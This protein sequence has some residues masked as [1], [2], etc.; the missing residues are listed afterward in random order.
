MNSQDMISLARSEGFSAAA[1]A[2]MRA[3]V[4]DSGFRKY[5]EE[6]LCGRY[7]ANYSCPPDCGTPDA[8]KARLSAYKSALVL[9]TKWDIADY[10][11]MPAIKAAKQSHNQAMLRVIARL[12]QEGIRGKMAGASCCTLCARCAILDSE[13]CRDPERQFSCMSAY[14]IYV[15][16]LA[17]R[18]G[19]EY[20]CSDGRLALF[21]LYA[22]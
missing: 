3:V 19:M 5:C 4:F 13:P 8:M 7:G 15:K 6:N 1:I 17:E 10:R 2:D 16:A 14:C 11:D 21:G 20:T 18:C 22:F 9:Q 12:K